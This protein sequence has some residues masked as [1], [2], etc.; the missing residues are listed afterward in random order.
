MLGILPTQTSGRTGLSKVDV[1]PLLYLQ[2]LD[3]LESGRRVSYNK[4]QLQL[5]FRKYLSETKGPWDKNQMKDIAGLDKL[6]TDHIASQQKRFDKESKAFAGKP[7]SV[8]TQK[9]MALLDKLGLL[10]TKPKELPTELR[11]ANKTDSERNEQLIRGASRGVDIVQT[12]AMAGEPAT[13]VALSLVVMG[14]QS[15]LTNDICDMLLDKYKKRADNC[16]EKAIILNTLQKVMGQ[17]ERLKLSEKIH[18]IYDDEKEIDHGKQINKIKPQSD[19]K[20][21]A[22]K[23]LQFQENIGMTKKEENNTPVPY[24]APKTKVIPEFAMSELK[25]SDSWFAAGENKKDKD[26]A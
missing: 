22:E 21:T 4:L 10:P 9:E 17:V 11:G 14:I 3:K 24:A 13:A 20:E 5:A 23:K 7:A 19:K 1:T 25:P 26:H 12:I 2:L 15:E 16:P 6:A 8:K 18:S